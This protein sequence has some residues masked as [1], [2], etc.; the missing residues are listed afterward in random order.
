MQIAP[1]QLL[2]QRLQ[3]FH[4][5]T[6]TSRRP[7]RTVAAAKQ[8]TDASGDIKNARLA[9][10]L[11]QYDAAGV[12][13]RQRRAAGA[14]RLAC[15]RFSHQRRAAHPQAAMSQMLC[16]PALG[17]LQPPATPDLDAPAA[18]TPAAPAEQQADLDAYVS[19]R[20]ERLG[21]SEEGA[22]RVLRASAGSR[23]ELG[24]REQAE[25][26]RHMPRRGDG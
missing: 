26:D 11:R 24:P 20:N 2:G 12:Q 17:L 25:L 1:H 6:A 22:S 4:K 10:I 3:G 9:R 13:R 19:Q 14:E 16:A 18:C 8:G 5:C 15:G 21:E 7:L 23:A